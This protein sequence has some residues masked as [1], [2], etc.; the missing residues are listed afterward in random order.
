VG[1][2]REDGHAGADLGEDIPM[3]TSIPALAM[4]IPAARPANDGSSSASC[5]SAPTMRGDTQ[6]R[7]SAG[8]AGQAEIRSAGSKHQVTALEAAPGVQTVMR[9]QARQGTATSADGRTLIFANNREYLT[10]PMRARGTPCAPQRGSGPSPP[11][12]VS[13]AAFHA[14]IA[15][16][17]IIDDCYEGSGM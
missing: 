2:G 1:G 3:V 7:P 9:G 17:R 11:P 14:V 6:S 8:A 15:S 13:L 12:P 10:V 16:P 5:I 4:P